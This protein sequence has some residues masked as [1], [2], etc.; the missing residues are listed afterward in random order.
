MTQLVQGHFHFLTAIHVFGATL[1]I[2]LLHR[3]YGRSNLEDD[4][5]HRYKFLKKHQSHALTT[6]L[7]GG[8]LAAV[9]FIFLPRTTQI[10]L[11][12]AGLVSISYIV[13]LIFR[14]RL[15]DIG[16]FKIFAISLAWAIFGFNRCAI[17]CAP[18]SPISS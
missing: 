3:I 10:L 15:R 14:K 8:A 18:L 12:V 1:F 13:P 9:T 6:A 2:Y 5:F 4:E 17:I 7:A 11:V 16:V